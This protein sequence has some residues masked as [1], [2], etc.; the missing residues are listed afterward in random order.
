MRRVG[1]ALCLLL[2]AVYVSNA[3]AQEKAERPLKISV[4]SEELVAELSRE[5]PLLMEQ[6]L[7]P[8][9]S[10]ALIHDG[11]V[12]WHRGFGVKSTE[13]KEPVGDDTVFE[14]ASLSKPVF[15]Y[16]V[17]QLV[18]EGKIDLDRPLL[19]YTTQEYIEENFL[20]AKL[21]DERFR[22]ITARMV[23][24]HTTGLPNWRRGGKL[25]FIRDPG[26]EFGYS[27]DGFVF[28]QKVV[29]DLTGIECNAFVTARVFEPLG[30]SHSGYVW[31]DDYESLASCCHSLLGDATP[32]YRSK[33][34]NAAASLKTNAA[35]YARFLIAVMNGTGLKP[36]THAAMLTSQSKTGFEGV[37]WGLGIGLQESGSGP[38]FWHWGDNDEFKAYAVAYEKERIGIVYF[39]NSVNGLSIPGE[40]VGAALGGSQPAIDRFLVDNYDFIGSRRFDL[41]REYLA[42]GF[43]AFEREYRRLKALPDSGGA[44]SENFINNVGYQLLYAKRLD[45]AVAVFKLNAEA[46]PD[47][48]NVYDS[49]GEAYLRR[50]DYDLAIEYYAKSVELNPQNTGGKQALK[51][52]HY[53]K[54]NLACGDGW[55]QYA[56]PEEAGFSSAKLEQ[57]RN[58]AVEIGS[59][60]VMAVYRGRVL[61]AWGNVE[62]PYKCHSVR[63]SFLSGLYGIY[64]SNKKIDMDKTLADL[65]IDDQPPLTDVEKS[66]R[67]SDMIKARSGVY[68]RRGL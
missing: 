63:K 65:G 54:A 24:S 48:F 53:I 61:A 68:Q 31:R 28:L 11:A 13:T 15:A 62:F 10:V 40:L 49:L 27:G 42:G 6:G 35:D 26:V 8:G 7:I 36:E 38:S 9:I 51:R 57:A 37:T 18:D 33:R 55:Q 30:M 5:I 25:Q 39:A 3:I 56:A 47:S 43:E 50:K 66:A 46:F 19:E 12:I 22:L 1:L 14:A 21:E 34:A 67:I 29:E 59:A 58:Y 16:A 52:L 20:K 17:L 23:L 41:V 64:V 45:D 2:L 60:A 44:T 4:A 32:M